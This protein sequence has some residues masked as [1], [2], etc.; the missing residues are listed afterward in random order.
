[1]LF[2]DANC[3]TPQNSVPPS[4][5][6][7]TCVVIQ[8]GAEDRSLCDPD[9]EAAKERSGI[10]QLIWDIIHSTFIYQAPPMGGLGP[11]DEPNV[12]PSLREPAG[13]WGRD[14]E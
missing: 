3:L 9:K 10:L 5:I 14:H 2:P 8:M 13:Q 12:S 1:M 4:D 7:S 11:V 6:C